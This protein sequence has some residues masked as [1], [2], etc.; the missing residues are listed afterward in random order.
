MSRLFRWRVRSPAH[1][2]VLLV[3]TAGTHAAAAHQQC[4]LRPGLQTAR[5]QKDQLQQTPHDSEC[6]PS[7][8]ILPLNY[9]DHS[10]RCLITF[11]LTRGKQAD[12]RQSPGQLRNCL[13]IQPGPSL[14]YARARP[15]SLR[16][17]AEPGP[18]VRL[19]ASTKRALL[20]RWQ[21]CALPAPVQTSVCS[22]AA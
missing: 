19:Q 2:Q 5:M 4:T 8:F 12:L 3:A 9:A 15:R 22:H 11:Q 6:T 10:T 1:A 14:R 16:D 13:C 18:H 17:Y 7:N 21:P 20:L